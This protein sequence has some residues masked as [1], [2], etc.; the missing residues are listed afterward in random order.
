MAVYTSL[1]ESEIREIAG[2]FGLAVVAFKEIAAGGDNSN[3]LVQAQEGRFVLTVIEGKSFGQAVELGHLL[4]YLK[5]RGIGTTTLAS[6]ADGALAVMHRNKPVLLKNYIEGETIRDVTPAMLIQVGRSMARLHEAPP[7]EYLANRVDYG[8]LGF[9]RMRDQGVDSAHLH[10]AS[11]RIADFQAARPSGLPT[12]LVHG[13]IFYDN[14]LWRE[15]MIQ[16]IIDF[17]EAR[18]GDLAFDLGAGIVGMCVV[19]ERVVLS[20]AQA[21]I[22]GYNEVRKLEEAEKAALQGFAEYAAVLVSCWR[23]WKYHISD[24]DPAKAR[25]HEEMVRLAK[26]IRATPQTEWR[27]AM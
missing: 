7:P 16:A 4:A 24:P 6:T 25:L 26:G 13:D 19:D 20:K 15:G 12:G 14:V 3:Y 8:L 23:Y 5:A 10:W 2:R 1:E 21:L 27:S 11:G 17:E 22:Q 9:T 18:P